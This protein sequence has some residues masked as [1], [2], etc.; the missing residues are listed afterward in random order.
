MKTRV[1]L[2]ASLVVMSLSVWSQNST[3][4]LEFW[5]SYMENGYKYNNGD[6]VDNTV[7]IS[8][9]RACSGIITKPNSDWEGIP[10]TVDDNGITYISIP[11]EYA[12]N[13]NNS[14]VVDRKALVLRATD[15][16]SVY[17]SNIATYSFDASFVLPTESLGSEYIIQCDQQSIS[18]NNGDMDDGIETSAFLIVAVED[19]TVIDITPTVATEHGLCFPYTTATIVLNMGETFFVKSEHPGYNIYSSRD[20]SGSTVFVHDEKKVAVFNGNT[21]TCIPSDVGNGRDHIF[22]QALPVDSWGM[23]FAITASQSRVRD[24]VKIVSARDENTIMRNGEEV[25]VLN[26]G[27]TYSF[28]LFSSDGSCFIETSKPSQ[29]YLYNTT[30]E[31]PLEPVGSNNGDPSMVWIPPIEQRIDEITF[32]TFNSY[33]T[34][35][36]IA[37]HYVNIV[38]DKDAVGQVYLD[39]N[40]IYASEFHPVMGTDDYYFVRKTISHGTHH[41]ACES[42]LIAHV[43]GFG[44]A[45][46]YAYCVGANVLSLKQKLLVNGQWSENYHHGFNMC[47]NEDVD[48]AVEA[49]Y[50]I[51]AVNWAFGDGLSGHGEQVTHHYERSGDYEV[52]TFVQ[53]LNF[54]SAEA[55]IDTMSVVIHVGEPI[56]RV[57]SHEVCDIDDFPYYGEMYTESGHYERI[58][59]SVYGCDSTYILDLDMEFSPYFEFVGTHWPIGGNETHVSVAEYAIHPIEPRTHI[60]TVLWS[61]EC[62]NW[63]IKPHGK[64]ESCTLYIYSYL[65]EPVM[66]HATAVNRCDSIHEDFFIQTSYHDVEEYVV[67]S[68]F[69]VSPNPTDG[70]LT[71]RLNDLKGLAKVLVFNS[72]WQK[73]DEFVLDAEMAQE[74]P[75]TMPAVGAGL[76]YIVVQCDGK[77]LTRKIVLERP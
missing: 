29:V 18:S 20:L 77:T 12:Y 49:N 65:L 35:A 56:H 24:I 31:E 25:I 33:Y 58:G 41:L 75:Y 2:L 59:T 40:I 42:G 37:H 43:Y 55:I 39:N 36:S 57:E 7:M 47:N 15:T 62:N 50:H 72:L 51:D 70:H 60:D 4:G 54:Y 8:A 46:G 67:V 63:R 74:K 73:V 66:L 13:E 19:S 11:E 3:Q 14:E 17:I 6:W 71:L 1:L 28:S 45:R 69:E 52:R 68:S 48:L 9:K 26:R 23:Q 64:G 21:T 22:E 30:G 53:G 61:I 38:V 10:F 16:V 34:F 76:Y 27:E 5:F 44:A 32:C